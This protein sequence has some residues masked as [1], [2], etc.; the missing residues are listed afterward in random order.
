[1]ATGKRV[2]KTLTLGCC[3][4]LQ[5]FSHTAAHPYKGVC[6]HSRGWQASFTKDKVK[7][8]LGTH[9]TPIEAALAYNDGIR[10]LKPDL[11]H[12]MNDIPAEE[13]RKY[14]A[15]QPYRDKLVAAAAAKLKARLQLP[16]PTPALS[17]PC[18]TAAA[19]AAAPPP[20]AAQPG[21]SGT[22]AGGRTAACAGGGF[23]RRRRCRR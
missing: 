5:V 10:H 17:S 6:R 2:T 3:A 13:A 9:D 11:L 22:S 7:L 12:L 19:A 4:V 21:S 14:A 15:G 1:M 20:A 23:E 8:H 16:P 18:A